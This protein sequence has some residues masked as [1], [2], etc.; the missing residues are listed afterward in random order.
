M[1]RLIV[2]LNL[3]KSSMRL[4]QLLVAGRTFA[5]LS[6]GSMILVIVV[7]IGAILHQNTASSPISLMKGFAA[8]VSSGLFK[9]MLSMELPGTGE[10]EAHTAINGR[11]ISTFLIRLLT[12]INP[13]D[14]KSL[15][16]SQYPGLAH[17]DTV[18]L[19]PTSGTD[20]SVEQQDHNEI[21]D[22]PGSDNPDGIISDSGRPDFETPADDETAPDETVSDPAEDEPDSGSVPPNQDEPAKPTTGGRKVVFIYHSHGRESWFPE[23]SSKKYAESPVK[24]ISLLGKRLAMQLEKNGVGALQSSTDYPTAIKD[25]NW[26]LSYKYS[27]KTV[28][29]AMASNKDLTFYFDI[30]RDSQRRKNT[31]I[32]INGIDYAQVYFIIGL[33]NANWKKN[34]AFANKIQEKMEKQYPGLSRGILGKS[35]ASGNG[36]Y[37]QSLSPDSVLIEIG[38]VDNT[39][40]E[41]YRTVDVLAKIIAELYWD[42][43]KVS[44][45][46]K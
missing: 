38:G 17:D 36:E 8:T 19:R 45:P 5:L 15:L 34:E 23:I 30:H 40:K 41:S 26:N 21:P 28:Q 6:I 10:G 14:P 22:S 43:E 12:D 25:Y 4:R 1:K 44:A 29:E 32:K 7:G 18:I 31:T 11:Q 2:T 46:A 9:D 35:S 13:A 33:G 27:K 24:N 20:A 42:A 39:L 3:A 37:N 16:A